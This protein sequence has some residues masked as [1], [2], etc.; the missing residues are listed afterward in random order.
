MPDGRFWVLLCSQKIVNYSFCVFPVRERSDRVVV[1]SIA[2]NVF[3]CKV[4]NGRAQHHPVS[5]FA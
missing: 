5:S 3:F 1:E 2:T 4:Q